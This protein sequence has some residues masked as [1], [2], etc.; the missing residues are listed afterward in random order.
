MMVSQPGFID[1]FG[2]RFSGPLSVGHWFLVF[3]LGVLRKV[4][5]FFDSGYA[6]N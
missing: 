4:L 5:W 6:N 2:Q 3:G 1:S